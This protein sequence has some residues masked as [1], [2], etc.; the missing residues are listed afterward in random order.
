MI[1]GMP[2]LARTTV[3]LRIF[4]DALDPEEITR[5]L[6]I[7][8][9]G[10]ARKGD[11]YRT[12]SGHEVVAR[13]GSWL[14]DAGVPGDLNTQIGA[15]LTK[16]PSGPAI[17]RELSEHYECDVFCGLFM[18][19][20]NEGTELSPQVMSMLGVRGLRLNLDIYEGPV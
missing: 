4:G 10:C 6:G 2:E 14:L 15:L 17:W 3:G 20:G 1:G 16:L 19:D 13:S 8:P 5:L 9:T 11:T 18:Q 7:E 12:A